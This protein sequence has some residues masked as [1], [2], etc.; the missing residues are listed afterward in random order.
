MKRQEKYPETT[1]FHYH[2]ENPKNRITTDCVIR[3]ITTA[4]GQDYNKTVMEMAELQCKTGY[5]DGDKKLYDLYL[6]G[7][8]WVKHSQPRKADNTKF[9]GKEF[10]KELQHSYEW[11]IGGQENIIANIGGHH[12]VAIVDA[13]VNDIWDS[14]DGCIGNYWTKA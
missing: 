12:I 4:L 1:T 7:K 9:T 11:V 8:G 5:D 2:N 3:A 10:C 13:K 14:T 6:Q